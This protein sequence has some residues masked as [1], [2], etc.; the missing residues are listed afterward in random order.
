MQLNK[1]LLNNYYMLGIVLGT[2]DMA[3]NKTDNNLCPLE[4]Y[5][6]VVETQ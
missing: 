1:Y 4:A 5:I 2:W 3:V 6:L